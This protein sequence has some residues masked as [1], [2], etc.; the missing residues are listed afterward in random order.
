MLKILLASR[1]TGKLREFA[2]LLPDL[3][4]V[5][6]PGDAPELPETGAFFSVSPA[7][8]RETSGPMPIPFTLH[9]G[10]F[11]AGAP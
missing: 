10:F 7:A 5:L 3:Q 11:T 1:N 6:W 8:I 4:F 9:S 2:A